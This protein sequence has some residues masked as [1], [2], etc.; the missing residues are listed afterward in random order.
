VSTEEF[1]LDFLG[2]TPEAYEAYI[3]GLDD[4]PQEG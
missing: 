2:L 3:L 1:M 4:E